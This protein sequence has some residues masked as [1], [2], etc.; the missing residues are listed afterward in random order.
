MTTRPLNATAASLLG[1]LHDGPMTGWDLVAVA[2]QRIGAFWSLTQSQVYRELAAMGTAGLVR[3]GERGRRDRQPYEITDAGRAAF[4]EWAARPPA[5]ETIRF[6]LL[7]TV[8]F[9]RHLPP[10]RLADFLAQHR[11]AHAERL[12]GYEQVAAAL[13]ADAAAVDPYSVATL[14]F[15]LAYERAAL[16]WFDALPPALRGPTAAPEDARSDAASGP[17]A[18]GGNPR[19]GERSRRL[20]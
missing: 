3:A 17:A 9:G 8:L 5:E 15:G 13:P 2:E 16:D 6:P 12:A 18:D 4:A 19:R 1:F 7:L 10:G 11:A 20:G 14:R